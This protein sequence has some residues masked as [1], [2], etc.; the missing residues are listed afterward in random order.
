MD[1]GTSRGV[2]FHE[3]AFHPEGQ[4]SK[5]GWSHSSQHLS[6]LTFFIMH[7]LSRPQTGSSARKACSRNDFV[8]KV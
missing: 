5:E 1:A 2:V 6:L 4:N 7:T 3:A 8:P